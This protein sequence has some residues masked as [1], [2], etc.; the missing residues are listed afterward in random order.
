M[1]DGARASVRSAAERLEPVLGPDEL[2][3]RASG[4]RPGNLGFLDLAPVVVVG[5]QHAATFEQALEPFGAKPVAG[6]SGRHF[7]RDLVGD[8]V[9]V[10][11]V[12]A[13]RAGRS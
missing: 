7:P 4:A 5:D 9:A 8:L 10:G 1:G 13:D 11:T 6:A 12:G 2:L 3:P